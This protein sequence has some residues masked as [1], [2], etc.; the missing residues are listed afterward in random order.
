MNRASHKFDQQSLGYLNCVVRLLLIF[1]QGH[2]PG[3]AG[4]RVPV[5]MKQG[6]PSRV[7]VASEGWSLHESLV[8]RTQ[9]LYNVFSCLRSTEFF[10]VL[11]TA[12]LVN[13]FASDIYF[14]KLKHVKTLCS[15]WHDPCKKCSWTLRI[16]LCTHF[17]NKMICVRW[18]WLLI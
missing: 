11:V 12:C 9:R 6:S 8:T 3:L 14:G 10:Y 15:Y 16:M 1:Q 4:P 2:G 13:I 17:S 5:T 7:W 18:T